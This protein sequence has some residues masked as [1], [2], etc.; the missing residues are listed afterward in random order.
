MSG[1][2]ND[3]T[4][5]PASSNETLVIFGALGRVGRHLIPAALGKGYSVIAVV[6]RPEA[7][8]DEFSDRILQ[9]L[10]IRQADSLNPEQVG[11]AMQGANI[12]INASGNV[13]MGKT[14]EDIVQIFVEQAERNLSGSKRVWCFAGLAV[15]N[16]P[17]SD[18]KATDL[19]ALKN[20][21]SSHVINFDRLR[22]S[23]LDWTLVC[24]GPIKVADNNHANLRVTCD[25]MPI[26]F[27]SSWSY[28]PK[29]A[30][31]LPFL[32]SLPQTTITYADVANVIVSNL[33]NSEF[34]HRRIGIGLPSGTAD[35][36]G[37]LL[38]VGSR[39]ISGFRK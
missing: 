23:S 38:E 4:Q 10:T 39:V 11:R 17:N 32:S 26:D 8:K 31:L 30:W 21:F 5:P 18:H 28:L 25:E 1:S 7:M 24:P 20:K 12:A 27:N 34:S 13:N 16:F 6:R 29:A 35:S 15:L 22:H 2:A 33:S 19:P 37:M 14:F 9:K 3:E 36:K